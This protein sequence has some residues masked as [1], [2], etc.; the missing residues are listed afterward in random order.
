[1]NPWRTA[2]PVLAATVALAGEPLITCEPQELRGIPGEPLQL[3]I[4]I[5]TD[6]AAPIHLRI[7]AV[8]NLVLRT[9]EKIPIQRTESGR[10]VQKRI[11][12]WQGIEAGSVTLTN[13]TAVFNPP[14]VSVSNLLET[15][16]EKVSTS[17]ALAKGVPTLGETE[18]ERT[19]AVPPIGITIDAVTPAEPPKTK[20]TEVAE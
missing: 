8:S 13:L 19:Q 3:E 18:G 9:V 12:L 2:L 5:E 14:V 17:D 16:A 11:I 15:P 1:M 7:P 10:Y 6:R 4:T 20:A